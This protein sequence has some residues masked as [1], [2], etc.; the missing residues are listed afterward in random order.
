MS[1]SP[2]RRNPASRRPGRC[3]RG[4]SGPPPPPPGYPSRAVI[5]RWRAAL[6]AD[7]SLP[8]GEGLDGA[9]R[10]R[11]INAW[12]AGL[13]L[14]TAADEEVAEVW[15]WLR[16]DAVDPAPQAWDVLLAVYDGDR[17]QLKRDIAEELAA[18][19]AEA[20]QG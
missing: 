12:W 20:A 16:Q 15:E 10:W 9:A 5:A 2:F 19:E 17:E 7:P 14:A 6:L 11:R 8:Y 18:R 4:G 13:D 3:S 1:P